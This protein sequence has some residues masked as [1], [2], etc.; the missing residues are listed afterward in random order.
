MLVVV[1]S[2][3]VGRRA[4]RLHSPGLDRLGAGAAGAGG[5]NFDGASISGLGAGVGQEDALYAPNHQ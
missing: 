3:V 4:L 1:S 5:S 2:G